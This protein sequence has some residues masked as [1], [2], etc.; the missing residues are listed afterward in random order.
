[1]KIAISLWEEKISPLFD[2][3]SRLLILE[4]EGGKELSRFEAYPG[5]LDMYAR[6]LLLQ[7]LGVEL[8]ICGAIS[9]PFYSMLSNV[10]KISVVPWVSG[11]LDEVVNAFK[12]GTL[13]R[14]KFL[15]PGCCWHREESGKIRA[16]P[17]VQRS[18]KKRNRS[19]N[20]RG[21]NI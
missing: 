8:L 6:S 7:D 10:A 15:M 5:K 19:I 12:K 21:G 20:K 17:R 4:I 14:Q 13:Y 18:S 9:R 1:M 16:L 11:S 3:S 2:T